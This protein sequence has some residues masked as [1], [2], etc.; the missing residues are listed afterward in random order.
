M[1]EALDSVTD[2]AVPG[3]P[4][5]KE[6]RSDTGPEMYSGHGAGGAPSTC[7]RRFGSRAVIDT[8]P[9][10]GSVKEAVTRFGG[11]GPWL[12]LYKLGETY[13]SSSFIFVGLG[14][15]TFDLWL[16]NLYCY[17]KIARFVHFVSF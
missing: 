9:P 3:T 12:P 7:I 8:S 2:Q 16:Y 5:I 11:S 15:F 6:I 17:K 4:G 14:F 1:A 10:F 13:V